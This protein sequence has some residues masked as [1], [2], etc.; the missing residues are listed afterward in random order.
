V[1]ARSPHGALTAAADLLSTYVRADGATVRLAA[2]AA[3]R[4]DEVA[5]F[6]P[7]SW[8]AFARLAPRLRAAGWEVLHAPEVQLD[9][10]GRVVFG[11]LAVALDT[12]ALARLP[13]DRADGTRPAPGRYRVAAWVAVAGAEPVP[14]TTAGRV[15]LAAAG[16]VDLDA[17]SSPRAFETTAA[18]LRGATW[19]V[20]PTNGAN[21]LV[22]TLAR[23]VP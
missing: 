14:E 12:A 19:A 9:P 21:D 2:L 8:L 10:E 15:A 7:E 5:L 22:A 23:A 11:P 20:S 18:M 1:R 16:V 3:V 17:E 4:S 6:T 13:A